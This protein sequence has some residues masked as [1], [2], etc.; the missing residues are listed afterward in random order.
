MKRI[1]VDAMGSDTYP[2]PDVEGAVLAAREYGIEIILVGDE[3]KI[4]PELVKYQ[5]SGPENPH[6]AR[7]GNADNGRQRYGVGIKSPAPKFQ[8][9]H[10]GRHRSGQEWRSGCLCHCREHRRGDCD[11]LLP[12]GDNPG[13]RTTRAG[14]GLPNRQRTR[15]SFWMSAPTPIANRKTFF[16]LPSWERPTQKRC[17]R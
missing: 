10:G 2:V 4:K 17:A 12:A 3:E 5:T 13:C 11:S 15:V 9:L 16:N 6:R 14:T 7:T 8:E 1:V